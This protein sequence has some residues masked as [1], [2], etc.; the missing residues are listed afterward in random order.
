MPIQAHPRF[1]VVG[2]ENPEEGNY[3]QTRSP[4]SP[5]FLKRWKPRYFDRYPSAEQAEIMRGK[6]KA[7]HG[8]EFLDRHGLSLG[9]FESV[10]TLFH[11]PVRKLA[12]S[13]KLGGDLQEPYEFNRRTLE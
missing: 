1:W 7:W 13:G 3:A 6:A 2:T 9:F 10:V 5:D 11:E 4:H 8:L 12:A